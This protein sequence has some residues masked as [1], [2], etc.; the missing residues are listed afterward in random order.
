LLI[1]FVTSWV[2]AVMGSKAAVSS[3]DADETRGAGMCIAADGDEMGSDGYDA[4]PDQRDT[5]RHV[6]AKCGVHISEPLYNVVI[7]DTT[8]LLQ[9]Q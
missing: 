6:R 7:W 9:G 3:T 5:S 8:D 2:Y 4:G 1:V